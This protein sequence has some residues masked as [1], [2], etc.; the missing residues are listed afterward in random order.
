MLHGVAGFGLSFL[1]GLG[2]RPGTPS[3][4]IHIQIGYA[5]GLLAMVALA[6][7][8]L[9]WD[10]RPLCSVAVCGRLMTFGPRQGRG[11]TCGA[12]SNRHDLLGR[13]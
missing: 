11:R 13:R 1:A 12:G 3:D 4:Q 8:H 6:S 2:F 7:S 10:P 9:A 5:T